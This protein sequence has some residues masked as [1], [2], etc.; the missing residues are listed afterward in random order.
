MD[1]NRNA[2]RILTGKPEGK[3]PLRR[4]RCRWEDN[5][6]MDLREIGCG[7]MDRIIWIRMETSGGFL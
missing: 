5:I 6:R 1:E 7:G 2:Y 3:R 4:P